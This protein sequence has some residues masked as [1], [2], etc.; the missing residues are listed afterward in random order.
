LT[1][2]GGLA[3][4][5][6]SRPWPVALTGLGVFGLGLSCITPQMF[7][8]VGREAASGT[9]DAVSV[10]S[11][12][13]Y[14]GLLAGPAAIGFLAEVVGLS[15]ALGLLVLLMLGVAVLSRVMAG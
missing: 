8:A 12:I 10:V 4:W 11:A 7:K 15:H 1:A 3:L 9:G 14:F 5:L 2:C 13:G 6:L